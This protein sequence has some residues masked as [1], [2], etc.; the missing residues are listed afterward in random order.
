MTGVIKSGAVSAGA[1]IRALMAG[2]VAPVVSAEARRIAELESRLAQADDQLAELGE[3]ANRLAASVLEA[4]R[5]GHAAGLAEGRQAAEDRSE[6]LLRLL[7]DTA[8]AAGADFRNQ[9][10]SLEDIA[11]GLA[12]VALAR[13]IG[14]TTDRQ[15]MVAQTI[16][17]AAA[18]IFNGSALGVEVSRTDFP[19]SASLDSIAFPEGVAA[20]G[21]QAVEDLPSGGCRI[22]LKLGEIDLGL[23]G[24]VARL[25]TLL[26]ASVSER[27]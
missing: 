6:E 23:D 26:D 12:G 11:A 24:Q 5:E 18:E 17:R 20:V 27:R 21:I 15:A 16:H 25:R 9:L 4:R 22:R 8:T 2:A 14:D 7:V 1:H 13:I 10:E 3:E 19:D